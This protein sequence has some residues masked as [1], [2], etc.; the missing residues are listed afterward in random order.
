MQAVARGVKRLPANASIV[1]AEELVRSSVL[2]ECRA[3]NRRKPDVII[4]GLSG[5]LHALGALQGRSV[6]SPAACW[7]CLHDSRHH[8]PDLSVMSNKGLSAWAVRLNALLKP[9]RAGAAPRTPPEQL[10]E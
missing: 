10:V 4:G 3:F 6:P 9:R 2:R 5:C 1:A 8:V 7:H